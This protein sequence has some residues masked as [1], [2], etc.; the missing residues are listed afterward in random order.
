M[1]ERAE[2][3]RERLY[4]MAAIHIPGKRVALRDWRDD[5][6][7]ALAEWLRPGHRWQELDGPYYPKPTEDEIPAIIARYRE[8]IATP[9]DP[10]TTLAIA[11]AATDALVGSVNWYW[12]S[13]ETLWLSLG[14][15]LYDETRWGQ[16]LGYEALGLWSD[17]LFAA[18]TQIVRLDL[19]TWSGN[20]G[21]MRLA[22]KVGYREEARFRKARIVAGQ[23]YD[24]MGYGVL[25]EE[26]T[27]RYPHG[28]A[29]TL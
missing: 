5:D 29:A 3:K 2:R 15:V 28:F 23:H 6:L 27:A 24:G 18:M 16:S 8:R 19:R 10:R 4:T 9:P 21:M 1:K 20:V 22:Q 14:I 25:R 7:P 17:Y 12:E 11:D 26:W 13:Q